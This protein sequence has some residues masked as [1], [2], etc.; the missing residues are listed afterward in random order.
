MVDIV[1]TLDRQEFLAL[2]KDSEMKAD[3]LEAFQSIEDDATGTRRERVAVIR[4]SDRISFKNCRRRW[5]WSSHLRH[6]LGPKH[7]IAPLWYGTGMHFALED[8]HGY[9]RFGHPKAAFEAYVKASKEHNERK[10]PPD[11]EQLLELGRNMMDY[12]VVWMQQRKNSLLRTYWVDGVPQ[13][14]VNFRFII[15]GDWTKFGYDRV[16]YSGT[17]DR[18]CID[19]NDM[20]WPLDYKS[21]VAIQTL[22]YLVDPQVSA[23]MWAAPH[24]YNKPVAGFIYQQHKKSTP[25]PGRIL[26][27]GSVSMAQNQSTS[28]FLYKQTLIEVYGGLEKCSADHIAFLNDLARQESEEADN[29]IRIDKIYRNERRAQSEGTKI[30]MEIEDMLNPNLPLYPNP[31]RDCSSFCPFISPCTSL[32]DGSNFQDE[33]DMIM[34]PRE[35]KYDMWRDKLVW[36][37]DP[38]NDFGDRSWL[39]TT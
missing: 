21:A 13:V 2:T 35:G 23:Y 4:T 3:D 16:E 36:P 32:D 6:N 38:T 15:P 28:H 7:G 34:E 18:V 14:E 5:G 37:D 11:W 10:L 12:Y 27:N 19:E 1:G 20:L 25:A 8:F 24:I 9:N 17:I 22:H 30:I 29:F 33:L 26:K 31:T 39:E